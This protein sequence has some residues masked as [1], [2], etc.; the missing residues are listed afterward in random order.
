ML[1]YGGL[2]VRTSHGRACAIAARKRALAKSARVAEKV[3]TRPV[4]T[5]GMFDVFAFSF[6]SATASGERSKPWA[7]T[8]PCGSKWQSSRGIQP[9][10]VPR[11]K[12]VTGARLRTFLAR[13]SERRI[14]Q[15]SVSGRGMRTGGLTVMSRSPKGCEPG[16]GVS[17]ARRG[18]R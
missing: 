8:V 10:P 16:V 11:S 12:R 7:R 14:V 6:A 13:S 4:A 5:A 9:V 15:S 2:D 17:A 3:L 18:E 1:I